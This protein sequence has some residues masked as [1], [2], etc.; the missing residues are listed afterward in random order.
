M[1]A[2]GGSVA[3]GVLL[4]A[5]RGSRL[6]GICK[7]R[8]LVDGQALVVRQLQ[9]MRQAGLQRAVV[10]MGFEAEKIV[11]ILQGA[12]GAL[13]GIDILPVR[14]PEAQISDDIQVSVAWG[15]RAVSR[16]ASPDLFM[17]LVDLPLLEASHYQT[18]FSHAKMTQADIAMPQNGAG[19]PGH[20]LFIRAEALA[21]MPL[22]SATFRLRDWIRGGFPKVRPMATEALAHFTDL[23]TVRDVQA[24]MARYGLQIVIPEN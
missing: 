20:P 2:A 15:L 5:G 3:A 9:V 16:S 22:E 12:A 11:E 4:C 6:G 1:T 10:V 24:L 7:G 19:V 23:D 13:A 17:T 18:V 14:L 8:I 21:A